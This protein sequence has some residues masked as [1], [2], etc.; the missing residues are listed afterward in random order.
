MS[1]G[2]CSPSPIEQRSSKR[3][4]LQ[5]AVDA[6]QVQQQWLSQFEE[7]EDPRGLQGKEHA[8]VSIVLIA[9][10][11]TIGGATGWEDIELY[12]E[13]HQAW[14]ESFLDLSHGI[15]HADTYRRVFERINPESLQRCFLQ[16]VN[17]VVKAT[18]AQVVPI[19]GKRVKGSYDR[20]KKQ[21]ALHLVSA[22]ASEHRLMLGQVKVE[23][24]SNEITA[25]PALLELLDITGCIITIDAMGTQTEIARQIVAKGADYVLSLKA[26]H[27]TLYAGV[28]AWFETAHSTLFEGIEYSYN[29]RVEAGHHRQ[30][31]RLL[32]AV[33]VASIADI[34]QPSPWSGLQSVVMV[35]RVRQLWN[36]TTREVQFYLS[37]LSCDAVK[38]GRA[39]RAH[40]SIENQL[41]WVLDVTLGE[42]ASR[43]RTGHSPENFALMR[44]M[45]MSLLNQET[46]TK[47]SLR[48]KTKRAAMDSNYMLQVLATTMPH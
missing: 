19:D 25:I 46:S 27:P 1:N 7:L 36:K 12:A 20:S 40:W 15:P 8:F 38:I 29:Q 28:K 14:L 43:I 48:Q 10:L 22:W 2:F 31:N 6:Q 37:S 32:W 11:A 18:G 4:G 39:I 16:W 24:K 9:I 21:S 30:E 35:L 45:A 13:S 41:H 17:Q 44:R 26:N 23:N 5:S 33:P 47:R 42:D 34:Y 3:K